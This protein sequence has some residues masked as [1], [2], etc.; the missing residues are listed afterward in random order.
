LTSGCSPE[1][2]GEANALVP[3]AKKRQKVP[4]DQKNRYVPKDAKG[5]KLGNA[6]GVGEAKTEGDHNTAVH[7]DQKPGKTRKPSGEE[8]VTKETEKQGNLPRKKP[9][10]RENATTKVYNR[11]TEFEAGEKNP[12]AGGEQRRS[13]RL[14]QIPGGT[15]G[16]RRFTQTEKGQL[17]KGEVRTCCPQKTVHKGK[18]LSLGGEKEGGPRRE[19]KEGEDHLSLTKKKKRRRKRGTG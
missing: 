1:G 7:K 2:G 16:P 10:P 11:R 12:G 18:E 5:T 8:N 3:A 17:E 13:D 15:L 14:G 19:R 9:T 4:S 6:M